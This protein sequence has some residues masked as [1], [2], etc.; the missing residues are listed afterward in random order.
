M[1][2]LS[3]QEHNSL[4]DPNLVKLADA[5]HMASAL[6]KSTPP[7]PHPG[8][9]AVK[10]DL[11]T[12]GF[13]RL[14]AVDLRS[15]EQRLPSSL[16]PPMLPIARAAASKM[17]LIDN[18]KAAAL[19]ESEPGSLFDD[20]V[21]RHDPGDHPGPFAVPGLYRKA[22][23]SKG[24]T[25][26]APTCIPEGQEASSSEDDEPIPG[27]PRQSP[28]NEALQPGCIGGNSEST[29]AVLGTRSQKGSK[30]SRQSALPGCLRAKRAKQRTLQ[31]ANE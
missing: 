10:P 21:Y 29:K 28:A 2:M 1:G 16:A 5:Y 6:S 30:L 17:E 9:C 22:G 15:K 24:R 14:A 20:K 8:P 25:V 7:Q 11:A 12:K 23:K 27:G 18:M 26:H 13:S 19:L 31:G 4:I 3:A